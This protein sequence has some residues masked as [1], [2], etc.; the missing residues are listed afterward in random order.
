M[1]KTETKKILFNQLKPFFESKGYQLV[2]SKY[3]GFI[4]RFD[5][6]RDWI[7]FDA[8]DF[9]PCQNIHYSVMKNIILIDE[10]WQIIDERY[11]NVERLNLEFAHTLKFSY[12]SLNSLN[13]SS[14]LPDIREEKDVLIN[15]DM[16]IEFISCIALPML[17]RFNDIREIDKEI[18]GDIFWESDWRKPFQVGNFPFHRLIIAFLC[19]NKNFEQL[20]HYHNGLFDYSN[21]EYPVKII[22][23]K[24]SIEY[25]R[26]ILEESGKWNTV[27]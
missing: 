1:K 24:N 21:K 19:G 9:N 18:N 16:I 27:S 11:F 12:E 25:L 15:T 8:Y 2:I 23:G 20:Y 22:N 26:A 14:Y 7:Y 13:K 5:S 4:K 17:E 3:S 6:G 10:I